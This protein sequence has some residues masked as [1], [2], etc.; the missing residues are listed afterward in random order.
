MGKQKP[1]KAYLMGSLSWRQRNKDGSE[2]MEWLHYPF[3]AHLG[4]DMAA[5]WP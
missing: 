4:A 1:F 3:V 5:L 2:H